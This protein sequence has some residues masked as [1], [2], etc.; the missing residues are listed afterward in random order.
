MLFPFFCRVEVNQFVFSCWKLLHLCEISN[1]YGFQQVTLPLHIWITLCNTTRVK[2]VSISSSIQKL[3]SLQN[4]IYIISY[5][6]TFR[7]HLNKQVCV[8]HYKT[9]SQL[10]INLHNYLESMDWGMTFDPFLVFTVLQ[11][12]VSI[13]Y[14]LKTPVEIFHRVF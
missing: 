9:C 8:Q 11:L 5:C 13:Y 12:I 2:N 4:K 6:I 7:I 10:N 3:M 14:L 1:S